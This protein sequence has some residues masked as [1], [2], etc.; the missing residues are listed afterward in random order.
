MK[1]FV[2][3][4]WAAGPE[5]WAR[6]TFPRSRVFSYIDV[7]DGIAE[8]ELAEEDAFVLVGFSMGGTLALQTLLRHPEKVR[9]LV[10]VSATPCMAEKATEGWRGMNDRRIA[11]FRKGVQLMHPDDGSP[12]LNE[13]NLDRGLAYLRTTDIRRQLVDFAAMRRPDFPVSILQSERDGIVRP[14]NAEFLKD[15]FPQAEVTIVPGNAHDLPLT[16]PDLIDAAVSAVGEL[17]RKAG[18]SIR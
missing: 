9:G 16:V 8:R 17:A 6:C 18:E 12:W 4:G 3:N 11:A 5:T 2:F 1:R 10:L 13:A 15:V 14:Q 7:L